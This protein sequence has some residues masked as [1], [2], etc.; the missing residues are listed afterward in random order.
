M[1]PTFCDYISAGIRQYDSFIRV[2]F[3]DMECLA[4]EITRIHHVFDKESTHGVSMRGRHRKIG[5][6]TGPPIPMWLSPPPVVGS[7]QC[8]RHR[9]IRGTYHGRLPWCTIRT[10]KKPESSSIGSHA[11]PPV[12]RLGTL[13]T[14]CNRVCAPM[15]CSSTEIR[16]YN[17]TQILERFPTGVCYGY[18]IENGHDMPAITTGN[19]CL[20]AMGHDF[21]C[22]N[23]HPL[24]RR[25]CPCIERDGL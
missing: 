7:A 3:P 1:A 6:Y 14:D 17:F 15:S 8:R 20:G 18:G 11:R 13:G 10:R 4:P 25:L 19:I 22:E 16:R 21:R 24:T 23:R 12:W 2:A 9:D 5:V